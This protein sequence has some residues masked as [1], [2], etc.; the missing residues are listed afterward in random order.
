VT[1]LGDLYRLE[2][3]H[4]AVRGAINF[5]SPDQTRAAVFVFQ[6]KDGKAIPVRPQGLD[7]AKRYTVREMN[8]APGRSALTQEGKSFTGEELMRDGVMPNC[9]KALEACV[10]ELAP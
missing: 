4:E 6:L 2:D 8:P 7:P 1:L 10:I 5:V 9:A 3:P